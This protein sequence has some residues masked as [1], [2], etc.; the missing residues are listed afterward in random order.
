M[1]APLIPQAPPLTWAENFK[2][3]VIVD[4][5]TRMGTGL[6]KASA[7]VPGRM[8]YLPKEGEFLSP[9]SELEVQA[10]FIPTDTRKYTERIITRKVTVPNLYRGIP[11]RVEAEQY[12]SFFPVTTSIASETTSDAGGG[13]NIRSLAAG[14]WTAYQVLATASYQ[15][16]PRLRVATAT[17]G[18]RMRL[19]IDGLTTGIDVTLPNTGGLQNWQTVSLPPVS[20]DRG[21]H[22]VQLNWLTGGVNLNYLEFGFP[23]LDEYGQNFDAFA[24]GAT[25]FND[26]STLTSSHLGQATRVQSHAL[27]MVDLGTTSTTASLLLPQLSPTDLPTWMSF[28]ASLGYKRSSLFAPE[29]FSFNY[30]N[31]SVRLDAQSEFRTVMVSVAGK[32]IPGGAPTSRTLDENR[33]NPVVIRWSK[34]SGTGRLS[35]SINGELVIAQLATPGF[36]PTSTDRMSITAKAANVLDSTVEI[37]DIHVAKLPPETRVLTPTIGSPD[38]S[39][40]QLGFFSIPYTVRNEGNAPASISGVR[41][42]DG[43]PSNEPAFVL[44]PGESRTLGMFETYRGDGP[45]RVTLYVKSDAT[46]GT[47]AFGEQKLEFEAFIA[48]APSGS[49]VAVRFPLDTD[50]NSADGG[51]IAS[52]LRDVTFG[53]PGARAYTGNAAT[54]NGTSSRIQHPWN[55]L[56]NPGT[57]NGARSFTVTAWA[58]TEG[59][60]TYQSVVTSRQDLNPNSTGYMLYDGPGGTGSWEFWS[61][62]GAGA[63]NWQPMTGSLAVRG[64][65]QHLAL[66]YNAVLQRKTLFVDGEP[67]QTQDALVVPNLVQPFTIGAGAD[68]G[69]QFFF[70]GSIDDVALFEGA[71]TRSEV[72]HVMAGDY[73]PFEP[74]PAKR[75][76]GV[77]GSLN[78]G[79][80]E[81]ADGKIIGHF[82]VINPGTAPVTL[83]KFILPEGV[84]LDWNGGTLA[85]QQT[86]TIIV[87][88]EVSAPGPVFWQ[89]AVNSDANVAVDALGNTYFH[90]TAV[91]TRTQATFIVTT[92]SDSAQGSLRQA[93]ADAAAH[94]G[95]DRV[96]FIPGFDGLIDL[97]S[98]LVIEDADGVTV[99]AIS[100][101]TG[102]RIG[103]KGSHRI[104]HIKAGT[105]AAFDR[106]IL[107]DGFVVGGFPEGYGGA[108]YVEGT[109]TMTGCSL[110]G[111]SA[112]VGGAVYVGGGASLTLFRTTVSRNAAAYGGGIQNEGALT[113]EASTFG[114]NTASVQGG[115]ISAPFGAPVRLTHTTIASNKAS[116]EGGGVIGD[117]IVI[118]NSIVAGNTAPTD[119]NLSGS[120]VAQGANITAGDPR[121]GPLAQNGGPT[122]TM[123]VLADSPARDAARESQAASDQ[124]GLPIVDAAD[125]GS[126]EL[127]PESVAPPRLLIQHTGGI[128]VISWENAPGYILERTGHF[129]PE[130]EWVRVDFA[131]AGNFSSASFSAGAASRA[132]FRLRTP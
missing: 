21:F 123:A 72:I 125:I 115:A 56:F 119:A 35:V 94:P 47:D 37:D 42:S 112:F 16:I 43:K 30:G 74:P 52:D 36:D 5:L 99:D 27:R 98:P 73:A 64:T 17:P 127:Q 118:Q 104:F 121:L 55:A 75:Y 24:D 1:V 63:E 89:V 105:T 117:Q 61:G 113:V 8:E 96:T 6:L 82:T 3:S 103:G 109:L 114:L 80:L 120:V 44:L 83:R 77:V 48:G 85:P 70:K 19:Q 124:R 88:K 12:D 40:L 31:L 38:F 84:S 22:R 41:R 11:G 9:G 15:Y 130:I 59:S 91:A 126:F 78:L 50:G 100:V 111:N 92:T 57:V 131:T 95:P 87:A 76:V 66:V 10:R 7:G 65:W 107:S 54:F 2:T 34:Q 29:T 86:R 4:R 67:V 33:F 14:G 93:L 46:A 69:D 32:V 28:E 110:S 132:F 68:L 97:E 51:L 108:L 13:Q 60:G 71:L 23:S 39:L 25:S 101:A 129:T 81:M 26:G 18:Q 58:R 102:V 122:E 45:Y 20:L 79:N 62:N 116:S 128:V 53:S 90:F 49:V 106:L